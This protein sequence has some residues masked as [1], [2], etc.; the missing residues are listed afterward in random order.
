[1][2]GDIVTFFNYRRD[3]MLADKEIA[4]LRALSAFSKE[5][6][7]RKSGHEKCTFGSDGDRGVKEIRW[8][9]Y[10]GEKNDYS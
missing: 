7:R 1:M 10:T 8:C 5:I 2:I 4:Y 6:Y 9:R 3:C